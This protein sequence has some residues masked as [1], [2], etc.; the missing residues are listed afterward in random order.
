MFLPDRSVQQR[1]ILRHHADVFAQGIL[2]HIG[3]VHITDLHSTTFHIIETQ[4]DVCERGFT[5]TGPSYQTNLLTW[6]DFQGKV[7][8]HIPHHH[9]K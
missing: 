4:Q 8:H 5:S 6:L 1:G 2:C 9:H 3:N 7:F